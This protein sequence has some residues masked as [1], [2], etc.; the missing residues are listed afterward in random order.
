MGK[1]LL[2]RE[3]RFGLRRTVLAGGLA[4]GDDDGEEEDSE[5]WGDWLHV[6]RW[7]AA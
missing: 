5:K 7:Q 1:A 3:R 6:S 4:A 2:L